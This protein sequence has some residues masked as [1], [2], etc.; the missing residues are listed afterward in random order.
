MVA[1]GGWLALIALAALACQ[2]TPGPTAQSQP[3][4]ATSAQQTTPAQQEWERVVAAARRE[5]EVGVYAG[6]GQ[7]NR[8][9]F[10]EPFETA[11]P[12][13]KVILTTAP[14][15]DLLSRIIA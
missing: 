6:A 14:P 8:E 12:G 7:P 11:Y 1:R 13:I 3:S 10:I 4:S 2:G 9:A 5:G 15:A